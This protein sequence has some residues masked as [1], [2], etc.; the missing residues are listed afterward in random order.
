MSIRLMSEV[1]DRYPNGA[2]EMLLALALADHADAN[3]ENIFPKIDALAGKTRQSPRTVQRQLRAMEQSTWLLAVADNNGGRSRA[4]RYRINPD[5]VNGDNLT[6]IENEKGDID[7]KKG[8]HSRH[9]RVT[10][11][12]PAKN[13]QEPS[14]NHQEEAR[15]DKPPATPP[16]KPAAQKKKAS[17]VTID[18]F[19]SDCKAEGTKP[20]PQTDQV[21]EYAEASGIATEHLLLCWREFVERVSDNGKRYKDW[22]KAFRNYVRGNY[23]R[24][25]YIDDNTGESALT[26][27]GK[28]AMNKHREAMRHAA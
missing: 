8:R 9:K 14:G 16:E 5:W 15:A 12:S 10:R 13:H 21:F 28:Q 24:L 23:Y 19:L 7:G 25:W 1:F 6:P 26:S 18:R 2:G 4:S 11:V 17:A 22:R 27:A 20:I 3:G